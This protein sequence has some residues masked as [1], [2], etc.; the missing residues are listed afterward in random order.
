MLLSWRGALE[1]EAYSSCWVNNK[2][3][4]PSF[5]EAYIKTLA[6]KL[7]SAMACLFYLG[8]FSCKITY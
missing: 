8:K 5:G 1:L 7:I 3:I 4:L 2:L 6:I